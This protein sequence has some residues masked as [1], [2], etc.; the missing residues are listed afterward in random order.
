M[1]FL[2]ATL[3]P[4]ADSMFLGKMMASETSESVI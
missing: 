1:I 4:S 3:S 2:S